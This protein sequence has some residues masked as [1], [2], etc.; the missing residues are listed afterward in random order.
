VKQI[1]PIDTYGKQT[2]M[3]TRKK[4]RV[5]QSKGAAPNKQAPSKSTRPRTGQASKKRTIKK[6]IPSPNKVPSLYNLR[7]GIISPT[8]EPLW[9]RV[10]LWISLL[11]C[12]LALAAILAKYALPALGLHGLSRL[13]WINRLLNGKIRSP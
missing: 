5:M 6:S 8:D 9:L 3:P 4:L 13:P 7:G 1:N 11:G 10:V 12:Y 2:T